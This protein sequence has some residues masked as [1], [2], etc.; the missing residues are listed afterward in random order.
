M[1]LRSGPVTSRLEV[2]IQPV[3]KSVFKH[4]VSCVCNALIVLNLRLPAE[5]L[6]I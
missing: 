4:M 3:C 1:W 2:Q 5:L 6:R